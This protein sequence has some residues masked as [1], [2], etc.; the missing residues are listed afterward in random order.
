MG[1]KN[2]N[3]LIMSIDGSKIASLEGNSFSKVYVNRNKETKQKKLK[4]LYTCTMAYNLDL[5]QLD[6]LDNNVIKTMTIN[7]NKRQIADAI[8]NVTFKHKNKD[9]NV[10]GIRENLYLKGFELDEVKYVQYKRSSSKART[11]STLFIREDLYQ[12]MI[13][14]SRQEMQFIEDEEVDIA[15]LRAYESLTLSGLDTDTETKN[16]IEIKPNQILLIKD[17]KDCYFDTKAS[18]TKEIEGEIIT[19]EEDISISNNIFDG[20]CLLDHTIFNKAKRANK[21]MMLLRNRFFKGCAFNTNISKFYNSSKIQTVT[22]I[23][24]NVHKASDIKLIITPSCLKLFKFAYKIGGEKQAYSKWLDDLGLFGIVKS[25]HE[26]YKKG[27]NRLA[28]QHI[29]SLPLNKSQIKE[30]VADE[31]EYISNLK[32][33][34]HTFKEHISINNTSPK[35]Q[36]MLDLLDKNSDFVDCTIFKEYRENEIESYIN[37]VKKGKI[38]IAKADYMV[39]VSN[40]FEMLKATIGKF[41]KEDAILKGKEVYCSLFEDGEELA[42]FRNPHICQGNTLYCTNKHDKKFDTYFNFTGNIM[43]INTIDNDILDRLQGADMDSDTCL[44]TNNPILVEMAKNSTDVLTPINK[45]EM[46]NNPRL[47]TPFE[48]AE[49]DKIICNNYIGGVVNLS[50]LLNSLY[51][52]YYN[53]NRNEKY[54]KE[55]YTDISTLSSLS[56]LEIDKAK[57]FTEIKTSKVASKIRNKNYIFKD[58]ANKILYPNFFNYIKKC[59]NYKKMD[60]PMEFLQNALKGIGRKISTSTLELDLFLDIPLEYNS[61]RAN[62]AQVKLL[63]KKIKKLNKLIN[64]V[65][66]EKDK[67]EIEEKDA[68]AEINTHKDW[69]YDSIKKIKLNKYTMIYILKLLFSDKSQYS[70]KE[71]KILILESLYVINKDEILDCFLKK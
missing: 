70:F 50:Q 67:K 14:W 7:G 1:I 34:I 40:P 53:N 65:Q 21:G 27:I 19:Q 49:V 12:K 59:N 48:I 62:K 63:N 29:N 35:R 32:N 25:E 41:D 16:I 6:S 39:L 13:S 4:D 46:K 23:F 5:I 42:G 71:Y 47:F 8:I 9:F 69:A 18:V 2:Q 60:C 68:I 15:S 22:D 58:E 3:T 45:I 54:L 66:A 11:G 52:Q 36:M 28:Y 10:K 24:G 44:L 26:N 31:V 51:W 55:I 20:Q 37:Q 64:R 57:K 38:H 33:D 56:Q 17:I 30:L 43:I 61:H